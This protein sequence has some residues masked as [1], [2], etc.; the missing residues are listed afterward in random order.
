MIG[1][2]RLSESE[3]SSFGTNFVD[4]TIDGQ[5]TVKALR[6]KEHKHVT[7]KCSHVSTECDLVATFHSF[8]FIPSF[9]NIHVS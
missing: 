5:K 7:D 9:R 3:K 6:K 8:Q 1:C 2:E 4:K